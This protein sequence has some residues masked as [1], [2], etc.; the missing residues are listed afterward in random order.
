M[1]P[2]VT[3]VD[4]GNNNLPSL[5]VVRIPSWGVY[6]YDTSYAANQEYQPEDA[7]N[8]FKE[9]A[10]RNGI[11]VSR[12]P[13]QANDTHGAIANLSPA[14]TEFVPKYSAPEKLAKNVQPKI[15][16]VSCSST[17]NDQPT[18]LP[19]PSAFTGNLQP[20]A[21][22]VPSSLTGNL[23]HTTLPVPSSLTSNLQPTTPPV[24]SSLPCNLQPTTPLVSFSSTDNTQ[25]TTILVPSSL[26]D[27]VQPATI[28]S[29]SSTDNVQPTTPPFSSHNVQRATLSVPSSSHAEATSP[30]NHEDKKLLGMFENVLKEKKEQ[31][32]ILQKYIK[33]MEESKTTITFLTATKT[34]LEKEFQRLTE[35]VAKLNERN[36]MLSDEVEALTE[37]LMESEEMKKRLKS[38]VGTLTSKLQR[39]ENDH[40]SERTLTSSLVDNLKQAE[41]EK[42]RALNAVE[43]LSHQ[44]DILSKS[45]EIAESTAKLLAEELQQSKR[46][47]DSAESTAKLLSEELQQNER[48]K[49]RLEEDKANLL[50][51]LL[52]KDFGSEK[53]RRESDAPSDKISSQKNMS[54]PRRM[55]SLDGFS[56]FDGGEDQNWT[57]VQKKTK[58][59]KSGDSVHPNDSQNFNKKMKAKRSQSFDAATLGVK[60]CFS[61][62]TGYPNNNVTRES[63]DNCGPV[64]FD[65]LRNYNTMPLT[66][67]DVSF[68]SQ[69]PFSVPHVEN[70][71]KQVEPVEQVSSGVESFQGL[72][73][74][75]TETIVSPKFD[76][77]FAGALPETPFDAFIKSVQSSLS[78]EH[79][80]P[81]T[82]SYIQPNPQ[83]DKAILQIHSHHSGSLPGLKTK[84][85][86]KSNEKP[87]EKDKKKQN[88]TSFDILMSQL[89]ETFPS[90]TRNE[91]IVLLKLA[92]TTFGDQG[93]RKKKIEEIIKRVGEIIEP[94][95]AEAETAAKICSICRDKIE[96]DEAKLECGHRFHRKCV[97][98]WI[99]TE[100]TCPLCRSHA[101]TEDDFPTLA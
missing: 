79:Q 83:F 24:S 96:N 1:L 21:L 44:Y 9:L 56:S 27:K 65:C 93:F 8:N 39:R 71:T 91:L 16:P 23:Q 51:K 94:D 54:L 25:P 72:N 53:E 28:P 90:K 92:K 66:K 34:A 31:S 45:N 70:P 33:D 58:G 37:R 22:P 30:M 20:T 2:R 19:V 40:E 101:L 77:F 85:D 11:K 3:M 50:S 68:I 48:D 15:L 88:L 35:E 4:M 55:D 41:M 57:V 49:D 76:T 43:L 80:V 74:S 5:H 89:A 78:L 46:D 47:K 29:V 82:G 99:Q 60:K 62:D 12:P 26:T 18:T 14:A 75:T 87:Q 97:K 86:S 42:E 69:E 10:R 64:A 32:K 98:Q 63:S 67:L 36:S 7:A 59:L 17:K 61:C 13:Q 81:G 38:Q 73:G 52:M 84:D 95:N 100:R 6:D